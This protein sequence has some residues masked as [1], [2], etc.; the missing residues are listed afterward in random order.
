MNTRP[1]PRPELLIG[2]LLLLLAAATP[3]RAD[4][5]RFNV[6]GLRTDRLALHECGPDKK[7]TDIEFTKTTFSGPWPATADPT[8]PLYLRVQV[9]GHEYC[10]KSFAVSTDKAVAVTKDAE[11][12]AMIAGRQQ[13][14][15]ATR[16]VGEGCPK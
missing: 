3:A 13:K 14:T 8:S 5:A 10:V 7:K 4:E 12:K 2:G 16:G 6:T 11:C 15:G 1:L 9:K